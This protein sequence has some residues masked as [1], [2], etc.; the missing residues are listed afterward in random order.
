MDAKVEQWPAFNVERR[1]VSELKPDPNNPRTHTDEQVAEIA[2]SIVE[3]GWTTPILIDPDG[4][5]I[6]GHGRLMAAQSLGVPEVPVIV[7]SGWSKAQIRAY[8]IADN[9]LALNAGW[10]EDLLRVEISALGDMGFDTTLLGFDDRFLAHLFAERSGRTDPDEVPP[11]PEAP[12]SQPGDL[13]RCGQHAVLCG[14]STSEA[15][16]G[17]LLAGVRPNLM[18]TD[19]PYGVNYDPAWRNRVLRADGSKVSAR[20]IGKV[21]NDERAD[22]RAAWELFPGAVAYIWHGSL[23]T[24]TVAE[25]LSASRFAL[26]SMIIWAKNNFAIGRSDY[27]WQHEPCWYAVKAGGK[28]NWQGDRTQSTIWEIPKNQASETGHSTQKPVECMARPMRNN[29]APGEAVYD[30]FLGS[31]S[32]V[33]AA[34]MEG[35][36]CFGMEINPAYVDVAV[37]RWEAF[38]GKTATLDADG[39]TFEA[40]AAKRKQPHEE[41]VA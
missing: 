30:P 27:H 39:S 41:A 25:S 5:V 20:A 9:Q 2:A 40:V 36:V 35:R 21:I 19:P 7:A 16:V 32:T 12:I 14:D 8:M 33:I 29:S 24:V 31:G 15:D 23:H 18:V 13:W 11:V 22:W 3:W 17:R 34:E 26:R 28:A 4:G 37:K 38:T 6:A 1:A 10:D